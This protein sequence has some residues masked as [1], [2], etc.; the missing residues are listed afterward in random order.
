[1]RK[2]EAP[3]TFC[4]KCSAAKG[5]TVAGYPFGGRSPPPLDARVRYGAA[6]Q[7]L[8]IVEVPFTIPG[9]RELHRN[10]AL[11]SSSMS[12]ARWSC[13]RCDAA[14]AREMQAPIV[15]NNALGRM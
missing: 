5:K 12:C 6:S 10:R 4:C 1:M 7:D 11:R 2:R 14:H 8:T 9:H 15:C 13:A 3:E